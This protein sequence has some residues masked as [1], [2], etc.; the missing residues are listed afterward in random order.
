MQPGRPRAKYEILGFNLAIL[1]LLF[2]LSAAAPSVRSV[3]FGNKF[4]LLIL[5]LFN[6]DVLVS[7]PVKISLASGRIVLYC[8]EYHGGPYSTERVHHTNYLSTLALRSI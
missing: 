7:V 6:P 3:F 4:P 1:D 5:T 2:D 8:T